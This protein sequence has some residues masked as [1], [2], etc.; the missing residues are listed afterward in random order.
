MKK[1]AGMY[2]GILCTNDTEFNVVKSYGRANV[3][4]NSASI[5]IIRGYTK[6]LDTT[7]I[8]ILLIKEENLWKINDIIC[9]S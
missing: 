1:R 5:E 6:I 7:K 2:D 3:S 9:E 4:G 8:K